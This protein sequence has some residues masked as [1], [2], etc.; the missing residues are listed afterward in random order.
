MRLFGAMLA[1]AVPAVAVMP[2]VASGEPKKTA[3]K[4][5]ASDRYDPDNITAISQ[6]M[7]TIAKGMERYAAKDT[8]GAIDTF[9]KAIQLAPK[10]AL[11]HYLLAEAYLQANN[12]GEAEAAINQALEANS[13]PKN[14]A[15]RARVLFV[16]AEIQERQK[17]WEQAKA[18]W[19]AYAEHVAK[20]ADA[21]FPQTAVERLKAIQK[22]IELEKVYVGV[23]ERIAAEKDGGAKK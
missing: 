5:A 9:K 15:M 12:L 2:I 14:P 20:L 23:R 6:Y 7:E 22:V 8:T 4:P 18:A 19:Q 13:D 21:G 10:Q 17:K 3:P 11:A 1:L 16:A